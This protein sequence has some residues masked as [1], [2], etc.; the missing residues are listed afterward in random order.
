MKKCPNCNQTFTDDN[1]FCLEDGTTLLLVSETGE[2]PPIFPTAS[3]TPTQVMTRPAVIAAGSE[4]DSSKWLF[5]II[6]I[7]AT[8]LAGLAIF[9]FLPGEKG[10]KS[11]TTNVKTNENTNPVK[12]TPENLSNPNVST[13]KPVNSNLSPSG[14][15]SGDWNS[16][17][18]TSTYFTAEV[19]LA[20]TAGR[21]SG[22]IVWTLQRTN[23]PKKV[24]KTGTSATEY[25]TGTFDPA[26]RRVFL[27]GVRKNDPYDIVILDRYNLILTENNLS[28]NGKSK[29]GNFSLR[30]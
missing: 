25:V 4:K 11:E 2:N 20:E 27:E 24:N 28:L 5:L 8:A 22:Q 9:M 19:E 13:S 12:N 23:N 1:F 6:G 15:W 30:R 7:L 14:N 10:E 3:D 26:T 29:G 16:T 18:K 17:G 21:V